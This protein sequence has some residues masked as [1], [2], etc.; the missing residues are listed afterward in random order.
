MDWRLLVGVKGFERLEIPFRDMLAHATVCDD[1]FAVASAEENLVLETVSVFG[2][3]VGEERSSRCK[4]FAA[5]A[6]SSAMERP[7]MAGARGVLGVGRIAK[8]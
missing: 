5:A 2:V 1:F 3:V 8:G 7:R 4:N 6:G